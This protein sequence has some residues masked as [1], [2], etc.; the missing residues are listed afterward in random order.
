MFRRRYICRW[1]LVSG[2]LM[3]LCLVAGRL[4]FVGEVTFG[5]LVFVVSF[6]LV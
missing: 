5:C 1:N 4:V 3:G 6:G 2:C